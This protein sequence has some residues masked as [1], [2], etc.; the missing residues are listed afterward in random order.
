MKL[1]SRQPAEF[2]ARP[3]M[4][5]PRS[6][7]TVHLTEILHYISGKL[8][9][10]G[11]E[12]DDPEVNFDND[13]VMQLKAGMGFAWEEYLARTHPE[14]EFHSGEVELDGIVGSPDATSEDALV[15]EEIKLSYYSTKLDANFLQEGRVIS[16]HDLGL[17]T[18][19]PVWKYRAWQLMSYCWMVGTV[20]G[21]WWLLSVNG[22]YT[23]KK[24]VFENLLVEF[25]PEEL[26]ANWEMVIANRDAMLGEREKNNG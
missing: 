24:P 19:R 23:D 20:Y 8:G 22:D 11:R 16:V 6:Q 10:Y 12:V 1:L 13:P 3:T 7:D 14:W 17:D 25:T 15:V 2:V 5:T 18:K 21:R 26:A 9:W 4:G